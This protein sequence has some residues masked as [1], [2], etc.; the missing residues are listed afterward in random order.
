MGR[1]GNVMS[2]WLDANN[3]HIRLYGVPIP[4]PST[5]IAEEASRARKSVGEYIAEKYKFRERQTA[6]EAEVFQKKVDDAVK[7]KVDEQLRIDAEKRGSN[8]NL[9]AGESSRSSFV[10]K[11]KGEDF[12][13]SDGNVP[14]RERQRR[15]LENLHKDVEQIRGAA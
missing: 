7:V 6:K 9:R 10:P 15:L 13:K 2:Q 11:I 3:E 4:D 1:V 5:N 8:P 14:V 12:H